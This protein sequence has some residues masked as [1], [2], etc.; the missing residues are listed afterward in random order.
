MDFG[1]NR[2]IST[3]LGSFA[4]FRQN[5]TSEQWF[6]RTLAPYFVEIGIATPISGLR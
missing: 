1:E 6:R 3:K 2:R 5:W 4:I